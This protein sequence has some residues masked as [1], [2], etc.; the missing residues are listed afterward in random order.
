MKNINWISTKEEK[1][2]INENDAF[3]KEHSRS[4]RV[5]VWVKKYSCP[6][7]AVYSH[8]YGDW[9]IEGIMGHKDVEFF[10]YVNE[11]SQ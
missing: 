4:V 5:L 8:V 2:V 11:P 7:F 10:A 3:D 6:S 9:F 1:P